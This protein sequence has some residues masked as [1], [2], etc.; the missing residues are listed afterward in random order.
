MS[1]TQQR[2]NP[3]SST[4]PTMKLIPL[5]NRVLVSRLEAEEKL[6][7]GIV[8]PDSAKKKQ[9]QAKVIAIGTGKKDKN[10]NLIPIPVKL[11]DIILMEKYSGQDVTVSNEEFVI[12]KADDIMA[13]IE[14]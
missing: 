5:G 3:Q 2:A 1:Q 12:I 10:G 8:L 9:E 4:E 13:I 14:K 6:K 7:G 11:G